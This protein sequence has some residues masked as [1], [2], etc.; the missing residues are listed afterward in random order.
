[1]R[2]RTAVR[3]AVA[4]ALV[5]VVGW[6]FVRSARSTLAE[7]YLVDAAGL[8]GWTLVAVP[9]GRPDSASLLL[10]PPAQLT[11][12]LFRQ[13]F[14]RSMLSLTAPPMPGIPL[15]LQSEY[16]PDVRKIVAPEEVLEMARE[17]GLEDTPLSPVCVG[18]RQE[19]FEGRSRQ[20]FYAV[21]EIPAFERF[22]SGIAKRIEEGGGPSLEPARL[23]PVLPVAATDG[24]VSVPVAVE[25]GAADC[26]A[27]L[28]APGGG[29]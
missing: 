17:A 14:Q 20:L 28:T 15:L 19:P 26:Q 8:T 9:S 23:G 22:R 18:V 7:P 27:P 10:Q 2:G 25:R 3:I 11:G 1:M 21:F 24:D 29:Q 5:G 4:V 16:G 12:E 13:I 6:L